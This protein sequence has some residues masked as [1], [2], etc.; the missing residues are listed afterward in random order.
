MVGERGR[1]GSTARGL[2]AEFIPLDKVAPH[3]APAHV[4][5]IPWDKLAEPACLRITSPRYTLAY[6]RRTNLTDRP[7]VRSS[8]RPSVRPRWPFCDVSR[9]RGNWQR[10][11][12][13]FVSPT[14][15]STCIFISAQR[16]RARV[17]VR[18]ACAINQANG[19]IYSIRKARNK[20]RD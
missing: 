2:H 10:T 6:G 15:Y 19:P 4:G 20:K 16:A 12:S 13:L 18:A 3:P 17:S 5:L 9:T 11:L 14:F 1:G 8:V 7:S